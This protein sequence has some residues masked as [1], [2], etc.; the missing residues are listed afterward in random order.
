VNPSEKVWICIYPHVEDE[1]YN[2]N[3]F[4]LEVYNLRSCFS[5][6]ELVKILVPQETGFECFTLQHALFQNYIS[7]IDLPI[8]LQTSRDLS[9]NNSVSGSLYLHHNQYTINSS[10]SLEA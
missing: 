6:L 3:F 5:F 1:D 7:V 10:L 8:M 9:L 4:V 2:I